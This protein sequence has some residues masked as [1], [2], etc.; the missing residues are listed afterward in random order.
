[1]PKELSSTAALGALVIR[2]AP[3]WV[4]PLLYLSKKREPGTWLLMYVSPVKGRRVEMGL[5]PA[6]D[7]SLKGAKAHA[8]GLSLA[9]A[10]AKALEYRAQIVR[11]RCPM[12][13]RQA[14]QSA[15]RTGHDRGKGPRT[16]AA[17]ADAYIG[18]HRPTWSN[19]KHG[20]Q[21]EATLRQYVFPVIGHLP[22]GRVDVDHVLTILEPIW[23]EKPATASRVRGRIETVWD[24]ARARKLVSG[25]NPARW[26]GHLDQLL[27]R[28]SRIRTVA[29]QPAMPWREVPAFYARLAQEG[30]V[31]AAPLAYCVLS[32]L[33]AG[34]VRLATSDE[35]DWDE[36]VH[37]VPP[38][39]GRK[40]RDGSLRVP[41]ANEALVILRQCEAR[42]T[43]QYL[44]GGTRANKP[45]GEMA[46]LVKLH[47]LAPGVTVH[48]FRSS[49]RDWAADNGVSRE[50][51]EHCLGHALENRV[52]AAYQR[53]DM[54]ERRR[55]VMARWAE[56]VTSKVPI[57][58]VS[59]RAG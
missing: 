13:E 41:L 4:A 59:R 10:K 37:T 57:T 7:S 45:I 3:Y 14:E 39:P 31:A 29:H 38:L 42:R 25:E 1:M 52:E 40:F 32:A 46:M 44:F 17:L 16:F 23:R 47:A 12:T 19:P 30:D 49:F 5:G 56:F 43:S 54:L 36:R 9:E 35:I 27:P 24:Y 53:S 18:F 6:R 26:K 48:G 15:K 55:A 21:W 20:R 11:G 33:R 58:E 34:A 2:K 8:S 28:P 22:V 51:A 50:T